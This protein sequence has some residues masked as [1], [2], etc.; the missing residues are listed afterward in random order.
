VDYDKNIRW[1]TQEAIRIGLGWDLIHI[2]VSIGRSW[3]VAR[4]ATRR[5]EDELCGGGIETI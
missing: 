5:F 2:K 3:L 4:N 1:S